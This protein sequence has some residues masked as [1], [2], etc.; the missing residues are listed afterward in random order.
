MRLVKEEIGDD[1]AGRRRLAVER[2]LLKKAPG[3][4]AILHHAQANA[5]KIGIQKR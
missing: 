5:N 1:V 3:L 2:R 4:Q